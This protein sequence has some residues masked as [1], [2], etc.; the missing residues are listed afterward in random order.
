MPSPLVRL[1]CAVTTA[2]AIIACTAPP[3]DSDRVPQATGGVAPLGAALWSVGD[4]SDPS[5]LFANVTGAVVL[6]NG[7][8]LVA[9]ASTRSIRVYDSTGTLTA[10]R[11][12][13]GA[14]PG[15]FASLSRVLPYRGDS[16]L[17]VDLR[18][19]RAVV[20]VPDGRHVRTLP[21]PPALHDS[22]ASRRLTP[23]GS[24]GDGSVFYQTRAAIGSAA[25]SRHLRYEE[26]VVRVRAREEA[27]PEPVLRVPG[28]L[29]YEGPYGESGAVPFGGETLVAVTDSL[30]LVVRP[31][32]STVEVHAFDGVLLRRI[33]I[34]ASVLPLSEAARS[35]ERARLLADI[36]R[37]H[38]GVPER[39]VAGR[40]RAIEAMQLPDSLPLVQH[41]VAD[42][43][44]AFVLELSVPPV[45]EGATP[46]SVRALA[47][48][49]QGELT[50][51]FTLPPGA[52]VLGVGAGRLVLLQR[53]ELG[54]ER[55]TVHRLPSGG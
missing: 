2:G 54:V 49:A 13:A 25:A 1:R 30:L 40:R 52:S 26:R 24:A 4:G 22:G 19:R 39:F 42:H 35:A 10:R 5:Q 38:D 23:V 9:E 37:S 33:A 53:D 44:G 51:S 6:R 47:F 48:D 46:L 16:V 31:E 7:S 8:V 27:A 18:A 55:V 36:A 21:P 50:A 32:G 45:A 43:R 20:L 29:A 28:I 11:G 14:G 15:E 12:R 3:A 41:L 34:P 17:A